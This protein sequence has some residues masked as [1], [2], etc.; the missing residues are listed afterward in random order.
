ME[1]S[2]VLVDQGI[3]KV[4]SESI[5]HRSVSFHDNLDDFHFSNFFSFINKDI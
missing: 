3:V 1:D 2:D 4:L 5:I